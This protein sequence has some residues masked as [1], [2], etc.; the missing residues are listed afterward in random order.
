MLP[1]FFRKL[2]ATDFMPHIYCLRQQ[3]GLVQSFIWANAAIAFAYYL[4]PITLVQ[5]V[6]KRKDLVFDWMFILFGVFILACG[7]THL[8]DIWTLWHPMYRLQAVTEALTAVASLA[9]SILLIRLVPQ[10]MQIPSPEVLKAE[11]SDRKAA[12]S[13]V[14]KLNVELEA[15]IRDRTSDLEQANR[16]LSSVNSELR[17]M[18]GDL[19][20][21]AYAAAHDLQE[22][23]R[24]LAVYS[25][26]VQRNY[27]GR[28]D[29]KADEQLTTIVDAAKR[30]GMLLT[31]L[32]GYSSLMRE[33][34]GETPMAVDSA[35]VL[36]EVLQSLEEDLRSTGAVV[37]SGNLPGVCISRTHLRQIFENIICNATKYRSSVPLRIDVSAT[38]AG[39]QWRFAIADNGIGIEE[40]YHKQIFGV[41]KRLHGKD[42]PG[43]G[44]GLAICQKIM[45]RYGGRIWVDSE[46]GRGSTFY[47]EFPVN[48]ADPATAASLSSTQL[49]ESEPTTV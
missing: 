49:S 17:G 32:L 27:K 33:Q 44:I 28:I 16:K 35:Q 20:Q 24:V 39:D 10:I 13:E 19:R 48:D 43:T 37:T 40:I 6:R 26:L 30:M 34:L 31:D 41:F 15:R 25:Q 9:T 46:V 7:T 22:P 8:L 21:F 42:V 3:P 1:D 4:I 18:N 5:I 29:K 2:F 36:Q 11:I 45:E 23:L 12:E 14:R 47:F 38:R